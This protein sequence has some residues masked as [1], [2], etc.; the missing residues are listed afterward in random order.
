MEKYHDILQPV[1]QVVHDLGQRVLNWALPIDTIGEA[2][3]G[4]QQESAHRTVAMFT[5]EQLFEE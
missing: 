4:V 3:N 1:R 2:F 5:Q